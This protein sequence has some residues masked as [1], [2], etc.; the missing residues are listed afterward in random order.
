AVPVTLTSA[1]F[2]DLLGYTLP[3]L[4]GVAAAQLYLS[5]QQERRGLATAPCTEPVTEAYLVAG[6]GQAGRAER[7]VLQNPGGNPVTVDVTVLGSGGTLE[8]PGGQ[9][10]VVA[11]GQRAVLLVDALAPGEESPVLHVEAEGG[12]VTA[13]LGDRWLAG[14]RDLGMAVTPPATLPGTDLLLPGVRVPDSDRTRASAQLRVAVPGET[15]AVVQVRLLTPE[16]PARI[17]EDVTRVPAGQVVDIPLGDLP[18]GHH[19]VQVRSDEPVVA[20]AMLSHR[21]TDQVP[22]AHREGPLGDL[23]WLPATEPVGRLAGAPVAGAG[24]LETTSVL[25]LAARE[26]RQVTVVTVGPEGATSE[27]E[28]SVPAAGTGTV[29]APAGGSVWVRGGDEHVHAAL[30]TGAGDSAGPY[31]AATPL[32]PSPLT[33]D[34][35]QLVPWLP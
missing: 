20:A 1:G 4:P 29:R 7:L 26:E 5:Q 17:G 15:E 3:Q 34:I 16:G 6:G 12:P 14:T 2:A 35:S 8:A 28:V 30:V 31:L 21:A 19:A 24:D 25:V 22:P 13:A 18:A 23:T 27:Q 11:P 33:R 9:G 32:L 10:V